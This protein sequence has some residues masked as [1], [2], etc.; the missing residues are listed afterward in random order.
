MFYVYVLYSF[1]FDRHYVGITDCLENRLN[2]HNIG[3]TQSTKAYL[4]WIIVHSEVFET[5]IAA[6]NREKYLKTAAG[7]RWR[8]QNIRPRGATE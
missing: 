1:K 4:P 5:R 2:E 8:K 3:K 7:R 6:R